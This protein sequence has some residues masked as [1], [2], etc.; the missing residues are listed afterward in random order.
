MG[1]LSISSSK[2]DPFRL[3]VE[4]E[5]RS[6]QCAQGLPAQEEVV[7][8]WHGI[9]FLLAGQRFVAPMGEVSEI[10]HLPRVTQV[11]GVKNW[12]IGVANVRGRLLPVMDLARFFGLPEASRASR[13]KR[14]LVVEHGEV[15]SGLIVDG[16][17]GMQYFPVD[18][19]VRQAPQVP[20]AMQ[21][22]V[23]GQ[24]VRNQDSWILFSPFSLVEDPS[25]VDVAQW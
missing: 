4:L 8:Y 9:G 1:S 13:D 5:R 16:V 19:H 7:E 22:F 2:T 17:Q 24:Y 15:F 10:L 25:F 23:E 11:P 20:S 21:P 18:S 14:V 12:M 6:K 3:L